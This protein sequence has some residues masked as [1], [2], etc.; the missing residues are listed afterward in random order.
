MDVITLG[1]C[2]RRA[3]CV[4]ARVVEVVGG[5]EA[6]SEYQHLAGGPRRLCGSSRINVVMDYGSEEEYGPDG[7][8]LGLRLQAVAR[9][10]DQVSVSSTSS[11]SPSVAEK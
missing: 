3:G 11:S 8:V 7:T 4:R 5:R 1:I 6:D 10:E 2:N 9:E